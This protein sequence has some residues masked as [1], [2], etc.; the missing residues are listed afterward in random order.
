[1]GSPDAPGSDDKVLHSSKQEQKSTKKHEKWAQ[2]FDQTVNLCL[3]LNEKSVFALPAMRRR[4][5][6]SMLKCGTETISES[7]VYIEH[8]RLQMNLLS[9]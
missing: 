5:F 2:T 1:M 3:H 9:T 7:E 4:A 6:E 8:E